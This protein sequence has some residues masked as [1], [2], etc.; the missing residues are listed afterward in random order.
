M[1]ILNRLLPNIC[2]GNLPET[3]NFYIKLFDFKIDFESDWFIHLVSEDRK[4]E[5]GIIDK[6]NELI[7]K[8]FQK[9]TQGIY[10]TFVVKNADEL[11]SIAKSEKFEILKKPMD[12]SY[13]QRRF[14]LKDPSGT[15]VDVSSPI[16]DFKF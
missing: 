5:L 11:F 2:S 6:S 12:T 13:G 3:K 10:I 14:L 1:P 4:L 7:P 9:S 16:K 8:D 15:L